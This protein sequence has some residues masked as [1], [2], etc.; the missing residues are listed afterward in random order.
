MRDPMAIAPAVV[1][2][3]NVVLDEEGALLLVR[4]SKA[5]A[6]GRWSLPAGRLEAG[7]SLREAAARE[8]FEETG[9]VVTVGPLLGIYHCPATL[10]GGAAVL[11]AFRSEVAGG[12][13]TRSPE[14]PEVEF[15]S[16]ARVDELMQSHLIR[17][18]HVGLALAA[19]DSGTELPAELVVQVSASPMPAGHGID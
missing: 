18:Q 4:E 13:L 8:A 7:E 12:E 16:R 19:A 3:A 11:F 2:C 1:V 10:E 17:G 15:L 9:L 6:R 14:H 5:S